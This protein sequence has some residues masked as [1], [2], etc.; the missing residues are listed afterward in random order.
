IPDNDL[1]TLF[2]PC[3]CPFSVY[4]QNWTF[5]PP[6]LISGPFPLS[7]NP[8]CSSA[9]AACCCSLA[10]LPHGLWGPGV[11]LSRVHGPAAGPVPR[12]ARS[13][14]GDRE[15]AGLR[16]LPRLCPDR[17][18]VLWGLHAALLHGLR[19]YPTPGAAFPLQELLLGLGR[20]GPR[21]EVSGNPEATNEVHST[22]NPMN[23]R[24]VLDTRIW[25]ESALKQHLKETKTKMKNNNVD[26]YRINRG[27]Q[28]ACQMELDKVL[29][30]ISKITTVDHRG[31][32]EN[33]SELKFPNCDPFGLYNIKQHNNVISVQV[34]DVNSARSWTG[35]EPPRTQMM[36]TRVLHAHRSQHFTR[37]RWIYRDVPVTILFDV[38]KF[39]VN[40]NTSTVSS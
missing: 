28:S 37:Q 9:C 29:E 3:P 40:N 8:R 10:P 17:G 6:S 12:G 1:E 39:P 15:G 22:E 23:R 18:G 5:T 36:T 33:L 21:V 11:P 35:T 19:C 7:K 13:V 38:A 26:E 30:E 16:V 32:L 31:P 2:C 20:C 34:H 14:R 24:P 4:P 25:Q 27:P